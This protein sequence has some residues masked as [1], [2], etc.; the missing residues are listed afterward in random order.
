MTLLP[1]LQSAVDLKGD[2]RRK[3]VFHKVYAGWELS[4]SQCMIVAVAKGIDRA[5][6]MSQK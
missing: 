5:H 6:G 3:Q 2:S 1:A 4:I